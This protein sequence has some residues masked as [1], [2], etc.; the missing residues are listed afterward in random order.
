MGKQILNLGPTPE[1]IK[2][3]KPIISGERPD[4]IIQKRKKDNMKKKSSEKSVKNVPHGR[5]FFNQTSGVHKNS[6]KN[7]HSKKI[8][9]NVLS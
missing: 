6:T 7:N 1:L 4:F 8:M 5:R 3:M 2:K 9:G